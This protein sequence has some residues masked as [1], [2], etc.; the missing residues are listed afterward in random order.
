V[1]AAFWNAGE[2]TFN[3]GYNIFK[4]H[5]DE[6]SKTVILIFYKGEPLD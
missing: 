4:I 2:Q 3:Q 5:V 6:V 1:N